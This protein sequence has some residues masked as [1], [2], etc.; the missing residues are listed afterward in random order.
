MPWSRSRPDPSRGGRPDTVVRRPQSGRASA[1]TPGPATISPHPGSGRRSGRRRWRHPRRPWRAA[2]AG[3]ACRPPSRAASR[4]GVRGCCADAGR[5]PGPACAPSV[6]PAPAARRRW[7]PA[8]PRRAEAKPRSRER[9]TGLA[10]Q[11]K[12]RYRAGARTSRRRGSCA[13]RHPPR[14]AAT[15]PPPAVPLARSGRSSFPCLVSPQA[16]KSPPR[17]VPGGLDGRIRNPPM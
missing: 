3:P 13:H 9:A 14:G 17:R 15:A 16:R 5:W 8:P 4:S 11:P 2:P 10:R 12:T 7:L 6:R 1:G